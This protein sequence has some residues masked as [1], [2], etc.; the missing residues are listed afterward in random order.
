M[1]Q[2][3]KIAKRHFIVC[4]YNRF[5]NVYIFM[6]NDDFSLTTTV[7][8]AVCLLAMAS[9][10]FTTTVGTAICLLAMASAI[11]TTTV[12]TVICLLAAIIFSL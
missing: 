1:L 11:F 9:A 7:G 10:L 8:L 2:H 12:G 6:S 5:N 3:I 4:V